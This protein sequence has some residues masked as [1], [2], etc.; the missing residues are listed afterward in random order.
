M[1]E[2][3]LHRRTV[4]RGATGFAIAAASLT[5]AQATQG[6]GATEIR[7]GNTMPYSGPA[8]SFGVLGRVEAAYFRMINDHGGVAG[9]KIKFFSL[10]DGYSPP[11]TVEQTRRL[12]EQDGVAFM[13]S[14]FGTPTNSAVARYLTAKRIPQLFLMTGADKWGDAR[15]FPWTMAW[16]PS[17]RTEGI[18]YAKYI[19]AHKPAARIGLLWQN[20]DGGKDFVA[21]VREGLGDNAARMIVRS[22]SYEVTDP[23]IDSQVVSLQSAGADTLM[24][25]AV[26][27]FSAMT[28]RR[29]YD[30]GWKPLFFLMSGAASV[31]AVIK[32]AGPEKAVGIIS[33]KYLKEA[34][35]PAWANDAG[36]REWRSFMRKY[37]PDADLSDQSYVNGYA[38]ASALITVLKLCGNDFSR[39]NIMRQCTSLHDL[40]IRVL[41]PGIRVNTGPAN[42]YP[43]RGMQLARWTGT[44]WE[45]FG[46]VIHG[47]GA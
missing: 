36:M 11:K 42:H 16:L 8:S 40:A 15:R 38:A 44:T 13:F 10:D 1:E 9:R 14:S 27:K 34:S 41:L 33:A 12:V 29:V 17:Y 25:I 22:A 4:L 3:I 19:L 45:R 47:G 18:I 7:I 46:Q 23:T 35:D 24:V 43:I 31:G 20:D 21:G 30:I 6:V 26:P 5:R 39:P 28:I 37:L 32:P 2:E